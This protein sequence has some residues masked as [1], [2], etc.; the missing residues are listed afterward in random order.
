MKKQLCAMLLCLAL[1]VGLLPAGAKAA[2]DFTFTNLVVFC[3]FAGE[4]E[5]VDKTY[6]ETSVKT[7]VDNTYNQSDYS[8]ADYFRTVS[9]GRMRMQTLYLLDQDGHSLTLTNSREY[10]ARPG[11]TVSELA[12]D[13]GDAV[14]AA[15]RA[16]AVP[17]DGNGTPHS[18][19]ELD[20]NGDG[21]MDLV[22]VYYKNT[23]QSDIGVNWGDVLWD[24]QTES[25]RV[26]KEENGKVNSRL[27]V[28]LTGNYENTKGSLLYRD[29]KNRPILG[30]QSKICHETMHA[31]GPKDLYNSSQDSPVKNM[32][33]MGKHAVIGQ[34]ISVKER[35]DLGWLGEG[36]MKT[37]TN[38]THTLCEASNTSGVVGYQIA[39]PTNK[40]LYLEYRRFDEKGNKYDKQKKDDVVFMQ[41]NASLQG[42]SQLK[43]G[44]VCYLVNTADKFPSNLHAG[45]NRWNMEVVPLNGN[46]DVL[47]DYSAGVGETNSQIW[48][49]T[50]WVNISVTAMTDT[51]LT[52]T[53]SNLP[54][55]QPENKPE[56]TPHTLTAFAQSTL[57]AVYGES[58]QGQTVT[59]STGTVTYSSS[60]SR[61]A[62]V[63]RSTGLLTLYAPGSATITASVAEDGSHTAVSTS[64]DLTVSPKALTLTGLKAENRTFEAGNTSVTL[65]GGRLE[66][67]VNQDQV[68]FTAIGTLSDPDVGENKP[69]SVTAQLTGTDREKYTLDPVSG[70]RVTISA[71]TSGSGPDQTPVTPPSNPDP[72]PENPGQ[73]PGQ[74]PGEP[75][76][77]PGQTPGSGGGGG[78]GMGETTYK[79]TLKKPKNG[80]VTLSAKSAAEGEE[81]TV[82]LDPNTGFMV[83]K[84]TILAE[85]GREIPATEGEEITFL[86]PD[87]KVTI[88]VE[89]VEKTEENEEKPEEITE[90]VIFSDVPET[91][92]FAPAVAWATEK[93]ITTGVTSDLFCPASPCTRGEIVT[94]L[95]R[96]AGE[97][98]SIGITGFADVS[99]DDFFARAVAWA[100]ENGITNGVTAE[101]FCPNAPCT[102]AESVTFLHRWAGK[103]EALATTG[104]ADVSDQ[105]YYASAVAWAEG[106]A[107]TGGI[108]GGL[109]GSDKAC[110]RGEIVT[111][112]YRSEQNPSNP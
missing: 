19:E 63:D 20:R 78:G 18:F 93:G 87:S 37:L 48:N 80:K 105:A 9:G 25:T 54:Q 26:T 112:L 68:S 8:V 52:F 88:S 98:Q 111:L 29:G 35:E 109:F 89:F 85:N 67:I 66:G 32:S 12:A 101:L 36:Q 62:A 72:T 28:Q 74:T 59:S 50:G 86:M 104:F 75:P 41:T 73:D 10:Y 40:S 70:L 102:R 94:F 110:T 6:A 3:K 42:V 83:K 21:Y 103:P 51:T 76:S 39:L 34:Y 13:W 97:P 7:I 90:K 55:S 84:V 38:G 15:I 24:Y 47:A 60:N 96:L 69:V 99:E 100:V 107:I 43:S 95:Y 106:R 91:S 17:V 22:T 58:G 11:A 1:A 46:H 61:V 2:E 31:L 108:G 77:D 14:N 82:K 16:G 45:A 79:I 57:S 33:L 23:E 81:I 27:Y 4:E 71:G 65:T 56:K 44:L 92:Y 49:G 30:I 64:Y 53:V 5:F